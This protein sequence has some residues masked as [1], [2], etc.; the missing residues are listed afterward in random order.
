MKPRPK[1]K[2]IS[3]IKLTT[4]TYKTNN[5]LNNKKITKPKKSN[6]VLNNNI[7]MINTPKNNNIPHMNKY[8]E[9]LLNKIKEYS[10]E[11]QIL[12]QVSLKTTKISCNNTNKINKI[13]YIKENNKN[14]INDI[15]FNS[16]DNYAKNTN[17]KKLRNRNDIKFNTDR[18][19]N[20]FT[21]KNIMIN[22]M[23]NTGNFVNK[24]NKINNSKTITI[25]K[26]KKKGTTDA[27]VKFSKNN[28]IKKNNEKRNASANS[29]LVVHKK[30]FSRKESNEEFNIINTEDNENFDIHT[31]YNLTLKNSL[32]Y[33]YPELQFLS[34]KNMLDKKWT[35]DKINYEIKEESECNIL[36]LEQENK[37]YNNK[38]SKFG[39]KKS[40]T[41]MNSKNKNVKIT[42]KNYNENR[43]EN[44]NELKINKNIKRINRKENTLASLHKNRLIFFDTNNK[45]ALSFSEIRGFCSPDAYSFENGKEVNDKITE[46]NKYLILNKNKIFKNKRF[47]FNPIEKENIKLFENTKNLDSNNLRQNGGSFYKKRG[48]YCENKKKSPTPIFN[49]FENENNNHQKISFL[50]SPNIKISQINKKRI[51]CSKDSSSSRYNNFKFHKIRKEQCNSE[52]KSNTYSKS[53]SKSRSKSQYNKIKSS[54]NHINKLIKIIFSIKTNWGN[55]LKVGINN[56]KLIDKNNKNIPIKKSNF[57]IGKPYITKY[58]KGDIKK[59]TIEL[60][61]NYIIKNIVILNGYNDIGIKYLIIENDRGKILWK[62]IIPKANLINAKSFY[63]SLDNNIL[64]KKRIYFSKTMYLNKIEN[65]NNNINNLNHINNS[66]LKNSR[67]NESSDNLNK[68]YV[69]CDR[70]K[71]KLLNSYGNKD[72]IGLSGIQFYDNNNKIINIIQNKKDIKIN[73]AIINLKEKKI[74]YNLF[75]NKNDST[76]PKYMFLTTNFNAYINITFKQVFKISKIIFYNYNNNIYKDYATKGIFIDFYINGKRKDIMNKSLYLFMPP[77]EEKIDYGQ[78]LLYPFDESNYFIGKIKEN[79]SEMI[80]YNKN[81]KIIFNEE[82]QYYC[83]SFPLGHIL[84]I[85]MFSNYGNKN[86]IGIENIQIFDE[87]NK[88]II[89][90]PSLNKN[91]IKSNITINDIFPRIYLMPEGT[92]VKT[93]KKPLILSKLYNFNEVN[94]KLGENRIYF[95]FNHC[96]AISK[97]KII[98]YEKY[99][100]IATKHIKIFLDDNIIFEGDLK[101]I[102]INNIYFCDKKYFGKNKEKKKILEKTNNISHEFETKSN[103]IKNDINNNIISERYIEYEGKNGV[104]ILKLSEY[105]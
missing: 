59:L 99:L 49:K 43:S 60:E 32:N 81:N 6:T 22:T 79:L 46:K 51:E 24:I 3:F 23:T 65:N 21:S 33:Y 26:N 76:N 13:K 14:D 54:T 84:K 5:K 69:L 38:N 9:K 31:S 91:K 83:P 75:N 104:K 41:N 66:T 90:F 25:S 92:Q 58:I 19:V 10:L 45:D 78:I 93:K 15:R 62:G 102:E 77:G 88:E 30:F 16:L 95:I 63:I 55:S 61:P 71:I 74:L 101:N 53:K 37:Q 27:N 7:L 39:I 105:N 73:E 64:S 35:N 4:N 57:D 52:S 11:S 70:I 68:N 80:L 34:A 2:K 47:N 56:L 85:E 86:Y 20:P 28:I 18:Q 103:E 17:I 98:N 40:K 72:Y 97:I 48:N 8:N 100:E 87:E 29:R 44:I 67:I 94:N 36:N 50:N 82:Y 12:N 96:I 1:P 89:L 42:Q